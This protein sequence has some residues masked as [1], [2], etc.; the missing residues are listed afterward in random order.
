MQTLMRPE[1]IALIALRSEQ[2]ILLLLMVGAAVL[3]SVAAQCL[4]R[5]AWLRAVLLGVTSGLS[6]AYAGAMV[7]LTIG[8][9]ITQAPVQAVVGAL[10][11]AGCVIGWF[12]PTR[13]AFPIAVGACGLLSFAATLQT[14][15]L[16]YPPRLGG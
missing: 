4:L 10:V 7:P 2:L 8:L 1:G 11:F 13:R 3:V 15:A 6:A 9:S 12:V 16:L 5:H 14:V